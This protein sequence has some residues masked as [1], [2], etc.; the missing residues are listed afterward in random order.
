MC[1]SYLFQIYMRQREREILE[2]VRMCG[3]HARRRGGD[4]GASKQMARR[5]P[6]ALARLKSII[7]PMLTW[8]RRQQAADA[9]RGDL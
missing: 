3:Y 7:S 1:H 4:F 8:H 9:K 2:D 5:I 6:S